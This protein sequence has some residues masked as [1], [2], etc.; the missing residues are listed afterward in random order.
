MLKNGP[1]TQQKNNIS[2]VQSNLYRLDWVARSSKENKDKQ[3][4]HQWF[5]A[6]FVL[7]MLQM[8]QIGEIEL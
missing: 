6:L 8:L 4:V 1:N 3:S 5:V 2:P 7:Q